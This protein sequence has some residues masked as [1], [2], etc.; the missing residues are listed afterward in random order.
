MKSDLISSLMQVPVWTVRMDDTVQAA[1]TFLSRHGLSW[2][3]IVSDTGEAVGVL[4]ADDLMRFRAGSPD[5]A[6]TRVWQLCTYKPVCVGPETT[7]GAV[8][9]LMVERKIHHVV[10]IENN[11]IKGVVSSLDLL[12]KL[13]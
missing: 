12:Q 10:V 13:I 2:V 1:E 4:S 11:D 9:R 6:A 7:I 5:A 3:P 8:A